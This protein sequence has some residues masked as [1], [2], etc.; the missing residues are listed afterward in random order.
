MPRGDATPSSRVAYLPSTIVRFHKDRLFAV[1]KEVASG[2][3][4]KGAISVWYTAETL[5][6][7]DSCSPSERRDNEA[8][9]QPFPGELGGSEISI[10]SH[11]TVMDHF[12]CPAKG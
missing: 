10:S 8:I 12:T 4:T 9:R 1:P 7:C 2:G 11:Q 3:G 6:W 5:S